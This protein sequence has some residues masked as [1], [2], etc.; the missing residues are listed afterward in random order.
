MVFSRSFAG[1]AAL[2]VG[3]TG[4]LT[5][6]GSAALLLGTD[7]S[8]RTVSGKTASNI[9]W[10]ENGLTTTSSLTAVDEAPTNAAFTA[11]FDTA[12]AQGHFAP[13]KNI[14]NEGPWSTTVTVDVSGQAVSL[15]NIEIDW[16][17]FTNSGGFQGPSSKE[18]Q[19]I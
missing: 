14:D 4:A 15:E 13:D 1:L 11:L 7:F 18:G 9:T 12:N 19:V 6:P 17:H 2:V 16:Q 5:L 8:G 3:G 10:S